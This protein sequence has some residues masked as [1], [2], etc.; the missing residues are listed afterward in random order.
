MLNA[1]NVSTVKARIS[2]LPF[3]ASLDLCREG[4]SCYCDKSRRMIW[5]EGLL[6]ACQCS[7]VYVF[8]LF[9]F[10]LIRVKIP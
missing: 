6:L 10:A 1:L 7:L 2:L 3:S 4:Q 8:C 5:T 9:Q